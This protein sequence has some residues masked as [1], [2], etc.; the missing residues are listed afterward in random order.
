MDKFTKQPEETIDYTFDFTYALADG[1]SV[2]ASPAPTITYTNANGDTALTLGT[3][4]VNSTGVKQRVSAGTDGETYLFSC[5]A[6]T[7]N[8]EVLEHNFRVKVKDI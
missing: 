1:D 3:M 2:V 4:T 8:G 6:T 5:V 7:N